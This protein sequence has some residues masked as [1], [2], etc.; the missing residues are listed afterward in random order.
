MNT[1]A[2]KRWQFKQWRFDGYMELIKKLSSDNKIGILIYGGPE[3]IDR[4]KKLK[5]NFPNVI[6]TGS[7]NSLREFFALL[8]LSDIIVTGD[9][10]ALHS[11]TAL[12]KQTICLFGPTSS[13]EIEDYNR[14]IK[15]K[16]EM[17][18][19]VCYKQKCDFNPNCMDLISVDMVLSSIQKAISKLNN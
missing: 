4:N 11:S 19:L 15:V 1:G 18:C 3:E 6:D 7:D 12:K 9:T 5:N 16:P 13:N 14:I 10:L 8:D 2:S 17:D